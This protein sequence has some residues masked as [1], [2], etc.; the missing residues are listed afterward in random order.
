MSAQPKPG[1]RWRYKPNRGSGTFT[2]VRV[3]GDRVTLSSAFNGKRKTVSVR[4]LC[5]DYERALN[6]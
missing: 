2:V 3:L 5:G 1:E 4:T 6:A